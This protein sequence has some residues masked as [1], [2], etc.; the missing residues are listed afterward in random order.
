VAVDA[1]LIGSLLGTLLFFTYRAIFGKWLDTIGYLK[2]N[3][4][5]ELTGLRERWRQYH[6]KARVIHVKGLYERL[7]ERL[8]SDEDI[9]IA[10]DEAE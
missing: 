9:G 4:P 2:A 1:F 10:K 5:T 3:I 8:P 6:K 7:K